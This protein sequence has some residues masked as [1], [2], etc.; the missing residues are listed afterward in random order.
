MPAR[1]LTAKDARALLKDHSLSITDGRL[2]ILELFLRAGGAMSHADVEKAGGAAFD[3]V[4]V[5]RT[6]Q[7]FVEKGLL[8]TIP[9]AENNVR[10]ALCSDTC[11]EHQ[12]QDDHVHFVCNN[13]GKTV[14]LDH[15]SVPSVQLPQGFVPGQVQVIV[16]GVCDACQKAAA[17]VSAGPKGAGRGR[18]A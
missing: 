7:S 2:R 16:N 14:C 17:A 6:L 5:Y 13:C 3:R 8:H 11:S 18:K 9:T 1:A 12:H 4:T 15:V 10:Y